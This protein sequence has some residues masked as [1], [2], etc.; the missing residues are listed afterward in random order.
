[1][2]RRD[3]GKSGR[4]FIMCV[5]ERECVHLRCARA[6][7]TS[8]HFRVDKWITVIFPVRVFGCLWN[9]RVDGRT[10]FRCTW[11]EHDHDSASHHWLLLTDWMSISLTRPECMCVLAFVRVWNQVQL[12]CNRWS[13][14]NSHWFSE[15]LKFDTLASLARLCTCNI[16]AYFDARI[17]IWIAFVSLRCCFYLLGVLYHNRIYHSNVYQIAVKRCRR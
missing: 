15:I 12:H 17:C 4:M 6:I 14:P 7:S 5:C 16:M 9:I 11:H 2:S 1:M 8:R 3:G 10:K 13:I